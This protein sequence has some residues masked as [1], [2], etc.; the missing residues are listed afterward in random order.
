[1]RRHCRSQHGLDLPPRKIKV[2]K[3][4]PDQSPIHSEDA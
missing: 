2:I 3:E 1:M 4:Q